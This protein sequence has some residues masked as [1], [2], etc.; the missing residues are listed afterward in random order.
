MPYLDKKVK[1][2]LAAAV[3]KLIG[4]ALIP[5]TALDDKEGDGQGEEE[6]RALFRR[7]D[8]CILLLSIYR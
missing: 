6:E 8:C 2:E 5:L 1:P 3:C 7:C 4:N